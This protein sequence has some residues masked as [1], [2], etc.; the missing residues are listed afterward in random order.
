MCGQGR[1]AA[2][3]FCMLERLCQ[4]REPG[5]D[6]FRY[7]EIYSTVQLPVPL[8]ES[9]PLKSGCM[10]LFHL[11]SSFKPPAWLCIALQR[12]KDSIPEVPHGSSFEAPTLVDLFFL[13][14][15]SCYVRSVLVPSKARSPGTVASDHS[16]RSDAQNAP[17]VASSTLV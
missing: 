12:E 9:S 14:M 11:P 15:A 13:V 8:G 2:S 7:A 6:C 16:V 10:M 1:S 17:F 3:H 5:C 4:W